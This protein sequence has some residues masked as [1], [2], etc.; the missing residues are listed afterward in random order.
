MPA[1]FCGTATTRTSG[2]ASTGDGRRAR[3][4]ARGARGFY[5]DVLPRVCAELDPA[6]AVLAG[7]PVLRLARRSRPTPMRTVVPTCGTSGTSSTTT[8]TATTRLDSPSEFGWQAPPSW[9]TLRVL[10]HRRPAAPDS[11]GMAHHQ[12]A[13][14]GDMQARP[15]PLGAPR[16]ARRLR[17]VVVGDAVDA[18]PGS[19]HRRSSTSARSAAIAWERSGGS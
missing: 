4:V 17:R 14:D 15:W 5:F 7:Q 2:A 19:H 6:R 18:S 13:T 16:F 9:Q 12:K 1:W 10:D 3:R 11:P 8:V